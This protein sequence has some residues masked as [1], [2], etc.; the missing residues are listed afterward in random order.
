MTGG[1]RIVVLVESFSLEMSGTSSWFTSCSFCDSP[2]ARMSSRK[3]IKEDE[4]CLN[5]LGRNRIA[6]LRLS[7]EAECLVSVLLPML[8]SR[9]RP[10]GWTERRTSP[11]AAFLD[12]QPP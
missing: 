4:V 11:S 12:N 2:Q 7:M 10:D 6:D 3:G 9:A 1:D 5:W 8:A